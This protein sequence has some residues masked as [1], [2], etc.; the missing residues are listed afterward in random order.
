MKRILRS[1]AVLAAGAW[2]LGAYLRLAL[3]TTRWTFDGEANF[4]PH[5]TGEPCVVAFW[6][7]RLPLMPRLW[8]EARARGGRNAVHVLSSRHRDGQLMAAVT[9]HLHLRTIYGS[10]AKRG[11]SRGGA[12][13]MRL[14]LNV[15]ASGDHVAITPDGP[16]GPRRVAAPGVAQ[17][18]GLS[19][20]RVLP[21]SGQTTRRRV[22]PTWDG[23]V[24]PLPF[25]RGVIV[26]GPTIA[27]PREGWE[28]MLPEITAAMD[29]AADRADALCAR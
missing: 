5:V 9:A 6:H 4:L 17:L 3:A 2:V 10:T 14:M 20:C 22:L 29:A 13:S 28:A 19:G 18:G 27:V 8:H 16:R 15:L 21:C 25:G 23:M 12:T 26:C 11:A 24:L 1:R 7:E